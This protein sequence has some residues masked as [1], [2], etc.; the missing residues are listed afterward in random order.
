MASQNNPAT[1]TTLS[2]IDRRALDATAGGGFLVGLIAFFTAGCC[3]FPLIFVILGV[4]GA[5]LS[6]FD[7]LLL[8]RDW[9]LIPA[10]LFIAV[11][12]LHLAWRR[13]SVGPWVVRKRT[14]VIL[15]AGT[16]L[17]A[18]AWVFAEFQG[19]I[20]RSLFELRAYLREG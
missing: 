19:D 12:W 14:I 20:T 6:V 15:C 7:E 13:M 8:Y 4:G 5:W 16:F 11:G 10:A 17:V 1:S 2:Q 9:F 3:A 18:L